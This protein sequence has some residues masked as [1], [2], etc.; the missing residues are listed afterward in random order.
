MSTTPAGWTGA[1]SASA[2]AIGE[3]F[4]RRTRA[5]IEARICVLLFKLMLPLWLAF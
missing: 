1:S 4:V 2:S 5:A 3:A